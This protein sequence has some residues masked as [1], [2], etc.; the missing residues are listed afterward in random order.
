[1]EGED[2]VEDKEDVEGE[3]KEPD[4]EADERESEGGKRFELMDK[5]LRKDNAMEMDI[6]AEGLEDAGAI[7]E[8][9]EEAGEESELAKD[10]AEGA[11]DD[12]EAEG[13]SGGGGRER[14]S[15]P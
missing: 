7:A 12:N 15:G 9:E 11:D 3:R 4:E 10:M 5:E 8:E 6:E 13:G 1:M 2:E 14:G